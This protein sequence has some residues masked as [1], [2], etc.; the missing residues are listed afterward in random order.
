[1]LDLHHPLFLLIPQRINGVQPR[2]PRGQVDAEEQPH[3]IQRGDGSPP[4]PSADA[5]VDQMTF[6]VVDLPEPD[7]PMMVTNSPSRT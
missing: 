3:R 4:C 6:I 7:G 2:G 1:M 5:G